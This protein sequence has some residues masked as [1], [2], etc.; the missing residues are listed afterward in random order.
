MSRLRQSARRLGSGATS[1]TGRA[2]QL[3]ILAAFLGIVQGIVVARLGGAD[4]KG[5]SATFAAASLMIFQVVNLELGQLIVRYSRDHGAPGLMPRLLV[6][7]I[8]TFGVIA[9]VV[10]AAT[11]HSGGELPWLAVGSFV[12]LA[13]MYL[14]WGAL[15]SRGP[16]VTAWSAVVQQLAFMAVVVVLA[17]TGTLTETT[18]K[19]AVIA[20]FALP[21]PVLFLAIPR[22]DLVGVSVPSPSLL[23]RMSISGLPWHLGQLSLVAVYGSGILVVGAFLGAAAAGVY[24]VAIGISR[25]GSVV[26]QQVVGDAYY[27]MNSLGEVSQRRDVVRILAVEGLFAIGM[28]SIGYWLIPLLY[29][30]EFAGAYW[31]SLV[32]LPGSIAWGVVTLSANTVK[33][34]GEARDLLSFAVPGVVGLFFMYALLVPSLG[35]AGAAL[36]TTIAMT[37]MS[38]LAFARVRRVEVVADASEH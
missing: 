6:R 15:A 19:V 9:A 14:S 2:V 24:S 33:V 22:P 13:N 38:A 18:V 28:A 17:G 12:V 27:R 23:A 31:L 26:S 32:L 4:I 25:L 11:L 10:V 20:G 29:G 21:L 7:T 16:V 1:R 35:G 30:D 8:G 34:F 36:A 37:A 3:R 5:V